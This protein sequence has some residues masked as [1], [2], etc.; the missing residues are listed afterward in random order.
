MEADL[1]REGSV[2]EKYGLYNNDVMPTPTTER[3]PSS[4]VR[5]FFTPTDPRRSQGPRRRRAG[6]Q[7]LEQVPGRSRPVRRPY[8]A[9]GPSAPVARTRP[10][11]RDRR[12]KR[13]G[14]YALTIGPA[15]R[16][17]GAQY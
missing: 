13:T 6:Q 1:L 11:W 5:I 15:G 4:G 17:D 3:Q 9:A 8:L 7:T 12:F 16:R 2:F 10:I 14:T